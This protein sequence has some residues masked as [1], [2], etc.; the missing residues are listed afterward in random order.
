MFNKDILRHVKL[1]DSVS[2]LQKISQPLYDSIKD[3]DY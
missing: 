2:R 3:M 1:P